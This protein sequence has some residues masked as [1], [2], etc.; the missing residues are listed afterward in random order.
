MA[1]GGNQLGHMSHFAGFFKFD[2]DLFLNP[3]K[4]RIRFC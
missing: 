3:E 4:S 2:G 1:F